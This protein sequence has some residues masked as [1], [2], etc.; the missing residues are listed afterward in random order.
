MT[1]TPQELDYI[2]D[3]FK[4]R[5]LKAKRVFDIVEI[6]KVDAYNFIRKYHYLG[7][8]KFF[9]KYSY[10]LYISSVLVGCATFTN[11][12]GISTMKSWF[13]LPN[14]NQD[15]LELS[16]LC[17][18]PELNGS[19]ASSYLLGNSMRMLKGHAVRAVVTLADSIRHVGSIYQVCNFV[20]YGLTNKKTD[21]YCADGRVNP[22]GKTKDL[23]GVWLPRTRKHRYCYILDKSLV[24]LLESQPSPTVNA[25]TV[26]DCCGGTGEV[27]D[28]RFQESHPCP[29]CEAGKSI[30]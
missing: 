15:V 21:F 10:G 19:N 22:R 25:T 24:P 6:S 29:K 16:R 14:S 23:R 17:L 11:P 2:I 13:G 28:N 5:R 18:L 26:V 20:Y 4:E 12:Q 3:G 27:A 30:E 9:S 1:I 8:A 7:D